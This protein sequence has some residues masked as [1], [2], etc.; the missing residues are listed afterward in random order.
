MP[1]HVCQIFL[2]EENMFSI[3]DNCNALT[4]KRKAF[5]ASLARNSAV[6]S[7]VRPLSYNNFLVI[8]VYSRNPVPLTPKYL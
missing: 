2:N 4:S 1:E 8:N 5:V 3:S 7:V 6:K